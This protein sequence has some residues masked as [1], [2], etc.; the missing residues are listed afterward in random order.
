MTEYQQIASILDRMAGLLREANEDRW[1][2][3]VDDAS[4]R[5]LSPWSTTKSA[6]IDIIRSFFRGMG[7]LNDLFFSEQAGN[8]PIG[9]SPD[10]SNAQFQRDM[11]DLYKL[12]NG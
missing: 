8:L 6:G 9:H 10:D 5:I 4:S 12:I 3:V 7:S 1:A 11:Q 2:E